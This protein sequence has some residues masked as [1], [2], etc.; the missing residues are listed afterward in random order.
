ML[1]KENAK[2]MTHWNILKVKEINCGVLTKISGC[3]VKE[4]LEC[5]TRYL[6]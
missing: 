1:Q 4:F 6:S 2:G 3:C 5:K